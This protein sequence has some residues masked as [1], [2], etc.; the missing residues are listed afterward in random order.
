MSV[1][2]IK[3]YYD[4]TMSSDGRCA[5]DVMLYHGQSAAPHTLSSS[6]LLSAITGT[7]SFSTVDDTIAPVIVAV[8]KQKNASL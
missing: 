2:L 3:N 8:S 6:V 5:T 1:V 7:S 4:I